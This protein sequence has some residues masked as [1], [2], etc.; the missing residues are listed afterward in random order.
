MTGPLAHFA[1]I[2]K[3]PLYSPMLYNRSSSIVG[4]RVQDDQAKVAVK[5]VAADGREVTFVF[6]L[7]KQTE[8]EFNNCWMT[9]GV[10]PLQD[11]D[12]SP[13]QGMTI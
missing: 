5:V 2:V 11:E 12:D 10:A 7:S 4:S 9:D 13:D 1:Q 6:A 3:S 8:G